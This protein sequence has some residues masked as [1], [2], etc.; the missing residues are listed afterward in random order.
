MMPRPGRARTLRSVSTLQ[1]QPRELYFEALQAA[2]AAYYLADPDNPYQQSGRS[3]GAARWEETRRPLAHAVER[4]GDYLDVGCANGLLLETTMAWCAER[5]L[6]IR[7]H[8][9][10]FIPELVALAR[11]RLPEHA[12]SLHVANAWNW[13]PPQQYDVVRTNLEHVPRADWEVFVRRQLDWV[14]P[15]GRLIVCHYRNRDEPVVDVATQLEAWGFG[16]AGRIHDPVE[17]AWTDRT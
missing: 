6:T 7:P 17:A 11:V 5:G 12:A 14:V 10:D 2:L 3:S 9:V 4:D 13:Q 16:V 15:G 1:D 8:G